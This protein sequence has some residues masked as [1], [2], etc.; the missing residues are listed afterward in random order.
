MVKC[1]QQTK[2]KQMI[3]YNSARIHNINKIK[4]S[5][6][7][8]FKSKCKCHKLRILLEGY[9][10]NM[11]DMNISIE[12]GRI[13]NYLIMLIWNPTHKDFSRLD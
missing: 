12:E 10:I 5:N 3:V 9:R 1:E 11:P 2:N 7:R 13:A 6:V 4:R 8:T